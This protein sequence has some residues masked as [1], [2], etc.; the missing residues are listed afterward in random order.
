M[1]PNL[2][3]V[4]TAARD[5]PDR[6]TTV[7]PTLRVVEGDGCRKR[8]AS[9]PMSAIDIF[10]DLHT[11]V[12]ATENSL[13]ID[14][15]FLDKI[16]FPQEMR[17]GVPVA[18]YLEKMDAAGVERSF[19]VAARAGGH[20]ERDSKEVPYARVHEVC[21]AHPGRFSGL[22]GIDPFRGMDG[23]REL[24]RTVRDYGFVGARTSIRIISNWRRIT[25][26]TI[27]TTPSAASSISRS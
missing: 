1:S 23:V 5:P 17:R 7:D 12:E 15:E 25:P 10:V 9:G 2:V 8:L 13:G 11:E 20:R 16:R 22:A 26:S 24:E 6:R 19:L 21:R 4:A 18:K 27:R 3:T 14:P